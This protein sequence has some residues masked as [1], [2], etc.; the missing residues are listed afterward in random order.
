[1]R[2]VPSAW[3]RRYPQPQPPRCRLVCLPH[4]GGSASFFNDWRGQLPAD[5]ELVSVQYPGREERLSESWP[6]SLEW[7]AGTI[8]RALSDLVDRPLVLFGHSM[9]AALA[10]EVAA[11]MQQQG[12]APQRLIVSAHPAPHRQRSGELHL[13]PDE[14][15]L[16][17]VRRL[18]DGASSPL[19]DPALRD[20]YLPALRND[21][22]LIECYRG[23]PGRALD[24]PLSVCL[25]ARDTE[26]DQDE[27]YAW[28]EVS[29]QVTDFQAFPGGH[30]YLREQQAELLRHLTRLLAGHGEQPWQCWPSTP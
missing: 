29:A 23:A 18:S 8:T 30:F 5:V 9:G 20:L 19:D 16:A 15:L 17:D 26:V 25:G 1:M 2:K 4:A 3:L 22:R 7:M 24:L 6:G 27:A 12:S 11:R 13:G 14:D 10:Y 28:A 21:Y